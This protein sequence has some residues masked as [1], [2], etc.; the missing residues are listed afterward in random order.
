MRKQLTQSLLAAIVTVAG[1]SNFTSAQA[2]QPIQNV[3]PTAAPTRMTPQWV[4]PGMRITYFGTRATLELTSSQ[5]RADTHGVFPLPDGRRVSEADLARLGQATI[6]EFTIVAVEGEHVAMDIRTFSWNVAD[7]RIALVGA[8]SMMATETGSQW[9]VHPETLH[10]MW[11]QNSGGTG[12]SRADVNL[13]GT[14]YSTF[15]FETATPD[16][17]V[18]YTYDAQSGVLLHVNTAAP[19]QNSPRTPYETKPARSVDLST[20]RFLEARSTA[21]PWAGENLSP[22]L[23]AGQTFDYAGEVIVDQKGMSRD[24]VMV[25]ATLRIDDLKQ[26]WC[27]YNLVAQY[28]MNKNVTPTRESSNRMSGA[29]SIGGPIL[30]PAGLHKLEVGMK[31]DE[32]RNS[33]LKT[34]VGIKS[35]T[36]VTIVEEAPG[37]RTETTYDLATGV[38]TA[39]LSVTETPHSITTYMMYLKKE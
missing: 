27:K 13:R 3:Q 2:T 10:K 29:G 34:Y 30:P 17:F 31:L 20:F 24:T 26:T 11:Q 9:F 1:F 18:T 7:G 5:I 22:T 23:Q 19:S 15:Q 28:A 16:S 4:Q 21:R 39:W 38:M 36:S 35:D 12:I 32:D 6:T 37:L 14:N 8:S 25:N 33:K